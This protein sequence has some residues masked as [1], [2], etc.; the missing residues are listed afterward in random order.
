MVCGV[1]RG[2]LSLGEAIL[3]QEF[4]GIQLRKYAFADWSRKAEV[5]W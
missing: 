3:E 2:D 4:G 5:V 1:G